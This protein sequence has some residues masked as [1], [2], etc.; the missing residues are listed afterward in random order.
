[1][2]YHGTDKGGNTYVTIYAHLSQFKVSVG[3]KV[4]QGSG[5]SPDGK[6]RLQHR[7]SS[8]L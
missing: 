2:I 1:M 3:D 8:S 6:Y 4:S 5:N 7:P